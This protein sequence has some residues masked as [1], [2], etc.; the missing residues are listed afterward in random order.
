MAVPLD[1]GALDGLQADLRA[2][3]AEARKKFP[4]VKDVCHQRPIQEFKSS[5]GKPLTYR[6]CSLHP[7][8]F[9]LSVH[10]QA[11]EKGILNLRTVASMDS[12]K[13]I[14]NEGVLEVLT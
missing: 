12:K 14:Y 5:T 7:R 9:T 11:A 2:L 10:F 4:N 1:K 8:V 3:S 13:T 6:Y